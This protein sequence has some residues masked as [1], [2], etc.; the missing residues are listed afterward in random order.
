V[1]VFGDGRPPR[2]GGSD[3][4]ATKEAYGGQHTNRCSCDLSSRE[5]RR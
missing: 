1:R 2:G 4:V 5:R 3:V